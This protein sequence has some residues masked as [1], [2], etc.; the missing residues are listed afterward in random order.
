MSNQEIVLIRRGKWA[1]IP[2]LENDIFRFSVFRVFVLPS[3]C[4]FWLNN[5]EDITNKSSSCLKLTR[6]HSMLT[7]KEEL[8]INF[9]MVARNIT[10]WQP[11]EIITYAVKSFHFEFPLDSE[12]IFLSDQIYLTTFVVSDVFYLHRSITVKY[13]DI[14]HPFTS[15]YKFSYLQIWQ[16]C[17]HSLEPH[18]TAPTETLIG[19]RS[20]LQ[21]KVKF[22][23]ATGGAGFCLSK[24]LALKMMPVAR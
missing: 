6:K 14:C 16:R 13:H 3:T 10:L 21:Q 19:F 15:A 12:S 8:Y 2:E 1:I 4:W 22:W 5:T 24:A 9:T 7:T 11:W 23:F 18:G 20:L 17:S